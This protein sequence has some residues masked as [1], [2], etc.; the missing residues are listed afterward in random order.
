MDD[1]KFEIEEK[2]GWRKDRT[3]TTTKIL[4]EV[5]EMANAYLK[6]SE[7]ERSFCEQ[8]FVRC[9]AVEYV[10]RSNRGEAL[11]T[12][13]I[14]TT[15][16][17]VSS[18]LEGRQVDYPSRPE[19]ETLN[20]ALALAMTMKLRDDT[21]QT[22]MITLRQ[23]C[24]LHRAMMAKLHPDAGQL[25]SSEV[26]TRLS[27]D[28]FHFYPPPAAAEMRLYGIIDHHNIH[29]EAYS[30]SKNDK[31]MTDKFTFLIKESSWLLF[32]FVDT[33]PF[34][35]GNGRMCRLL[36]NYVLSILLPFPV[37]LCGNRD[38][39]LSAIARCRRNPKEGPRD[40]AAML[41]E[42][43]LQGYKH[44]FQTLDAR[45]QSASL[46]NQLGPVIVQ[47][48]KVKDVKVIHDR[49][50]RACSKDTSIAM[51]ELTQTVVGAIAH[52][53][54]SKMELHQYKHTL[55]PVDDTRYLSLN[56]FP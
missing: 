29:M 34:A 12:D 21:S 14:E 39:Y 13:S 5:V 18:V 48:G 36:A 41:I 28:S 3:V 6:R 33:H 52:V 7:E 25:R 9:M 43:A 17:I 8:H 54:V 26:F 47:K 2:P 35:D 27:A 44:L 51:D 45:E 31:S 42:G 20:T 53:D 56:V 50:K 24:D 55:V 49:I 4:R 30:L 22:G 40:L 15:G 32:N 37:H 23:L 38:E 11:G 16:A 10:H 19:R 46:S 1:L